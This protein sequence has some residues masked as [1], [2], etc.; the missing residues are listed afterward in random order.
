[1]WCECDWGMI[2][3][4]ALILFNWP[5]AFAPFLGNL[6]YLH[7][8]FFSS[9][10]E[11]SGMPIESFFCLKIMK[12]LPSQGSLCHLRPYPHGSSYNKHQLYSVTLTCSRDF[13][14]IF[15]S[16]ATATIPPPPR[17]GHLH[18]HA[19][20]NYCWMISLWWPTSTFKINQVWISFSPFW[21]TENQT[22]QRLYSSPLCDVVVCHL[23]LTLLHA[24][25]YAFFSSFFAC[26]FCI[27]S[28]Y[29]YINFLMTNTLC[30]KTDCPVVIVH[31]I[32][33]GVI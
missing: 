7:I 20:S 26:L 30:I 10:I 5:S 1:M 13:I 9:Y 27:P 15:A 19:Q 3:W 29:V 23:G 2:V 14:C 28:N 25:G 31:C 22:K 11:V 21:G 24:F 12:R 18:P 4:N 32:I 17:R 16:A 8:Y 6:Q 33:L